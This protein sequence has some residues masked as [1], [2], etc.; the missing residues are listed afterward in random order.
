[1]KIGIIVAMDKEMALLKPQLGGTTD[2]SANGFD[3]HIGTLGGHQI[4]ACKCGIGKINAAIG[5]MT[6]IDMFHPSMVINTGVAG[7]TGKG[8]NPAGILDVVLADH[9]AFHDVWCGPGT[10]WGQAA[11]CPE[12]FE[13]PLPESVAAQIG[14]RHGLLASGDTFID[15]QEQMS[16]VLAHQPEAVA[17]D[18]ESGAIAQVCHIKDVPFACLRVISDT[19]GSEGNAVAYDAFWENAPEKTFEAVEKLLKLL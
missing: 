12:A 11:G 7:S 4:I 2:V 16:E 9:I 5:A 14:A 1:M 8:E 15:T 17:V 19:P 13:C 10:K 3:F 6:L 18:M